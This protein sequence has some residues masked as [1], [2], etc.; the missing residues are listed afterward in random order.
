MQ[1]FTTFR[2]TIKRLVCS[3]LEP[4]RVQAFR[5]AF[6]GFLELPGEAPGR[7][8]RAAPQPERR[9]FSGA[10][11]A[12]GPALPRAR[13][14]TVCVDA[15]GEDGDGLCRELRAYAVA[16]MRRQ[17]F[18]YDLGGADSAAIGRRGGWSFGARLG[19]HFDD[20]D[21]T[22]YDRYAAMGYETRVGR[23]AWRTHLDYVL[24]EVNIEDTV[25]LRL[26]D[27]QEWFFETFRSGFAPF[28]RKREDPSVQRFHDMLPTLM[29]AELGGNAAT[30]AVGR[31]LRAMG[32]RAF[33]YPAARSDP[34]AIVHLGTLRASVGFNLVEFQGTP[35][36]GDGEEHMVFDDPEPWGTSVFWP[37]LRCEVAELGKTP[38][39]ARPFRG[40]WRLR[41][42]REAH[43]RF[44]Q[45]GG[46]L[47]AEQDD[48]EQTLIRARIGIRR[49]LERVG[50][51][52][53][54][55]QSEEGPGGAGR[56][57]ISRAE[58]GRADAERADTGRERPN[59]ERDRA[60][61]A[62][63]GDRLR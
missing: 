10:L 26:P 15:S 45:Q 31:V 32:A 4:A 57:E 13:Y 23:A 9:R 12:V 49:T 11:F 40:S 61:G 6:P 1:P 60:P 24:E 2:A 3:G 54:L 36:P 7:A 27:T 47:G 63:P 21:S 50:W 58:T 44:W 34:D 59:G 16:A 14:A 43:E 41:G 55:E 19:L 62:A 53:V 33:V 42:V 22:L 20:P 5:A 28:W 8:E 35:V 37:R 29:T 38:E 17:V 52:A 46:H 48:G 56:K 51:D 30:D 39:L 25:D 18:I